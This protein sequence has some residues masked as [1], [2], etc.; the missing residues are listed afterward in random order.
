MI[1]TNLYSD[2]WTTDWSNNGNGWIGGWHI[3]SNDIYL[4]GN[5]THTSTSNNINQDLFCINKENGWAA[6]ISFDGS[7]WITDWHNSGSHYIGSFNIQHPYSYV[8]FPY[9]Y[10]NRNFLMA[11]VYQENLA[12]LYSIDRFGNS[13][14]V[15][16][17]NCTNYINGWL[18]RS[19]DKFVVG[20]FDYYG[21]G[22]ELMLINPSGGWA[23][24]SRFNY[25]SF[26]DLWSNGGNGSLPGWILRTTDRYFAADVDNDNIDELVC[27]SPVNGWAAIF[28]YK[29]NTWS[30]IWANGGNYSLGGWEI[31]SQCL[32]AGYN[33]DSDTNEEIF[34]INPYN[35]WCTIKNYNS[36]QSWPDS[37]TN[38]GNH[39]ING[40]YIQRSDTYNFGNFNL[41]TVNPPK[42]FFP[43]NRPTGW[44]SLMHLIPGPFDKELI[45]KTLISNSKV[46][47]KPEN[48]LLEQNF[49]NPFNPTTKINYS[50]PNNDQVKIIIYDLLGN[51]VK[52]LVDGNRT[53]GIYEVDFDATDLASG[54]YIY[55]MIASN[56]I[57]TKKMTIIK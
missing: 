48:F 20:N 14:E 55:K 19:T 32:W 51:E 41:A 23:Y 7:N 12:C 30:A 3:A 52:V 9:F 28:R 13:F 53:A 42:H 57:E 56:F 26:Q 1:S 43:I 27:I 29:N 5:F 21:S 18:M 49:P 4:T 38:Y 2:I 54:T 47:S 16:Y 15:N 8:Y 24:L 39:W 45:N 11:F 35:G 33:L 50:V 44:A 37:W 6:S 34:N 22:D 25:V 10:G 36:T 17:E 31:N 46:I 40:W